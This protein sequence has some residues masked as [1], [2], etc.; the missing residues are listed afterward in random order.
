VFFCILCILAET[1]DGDADDM[2]KTLVAPSEV[3]DATT[4]SADK[5]PDAETTTVSTVPIAPSTPAIVVSDSNKKT[6]SK[7]SVKSNE[8]V[9]K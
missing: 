9:K 3:P 2:D 4:D 5:Q 1:S 7:K 6:D 8:N